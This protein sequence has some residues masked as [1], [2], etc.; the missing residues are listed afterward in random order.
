[1]NYKTSNQSIALNAKAR[2]PEKEDIL[3]Y[4]LKHY[5]CTFNCQR[6]YSAKKYA[7]ETT[8]RRQHIS[9]PVFYYDLN[10]N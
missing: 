5:M 10:L 2:Q 4:S 3:S 9:A 7:V 8:G 1:M 6:I